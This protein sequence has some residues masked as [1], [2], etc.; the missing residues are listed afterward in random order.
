VKSI[1]YKASVKKDITI[2]KYVVIIQIKKDCFKHT[3]IRLYL[4]IDIK[5]L[6]YVLGIYIS[7]A[8]YPLDVVF[9]FFMI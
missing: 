8:K 3:S 6:L 1:K 2:E 7:S 5:S 9:F 4:L